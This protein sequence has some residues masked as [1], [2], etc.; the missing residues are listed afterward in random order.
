MDGLNLAWDLEDMKWPALSR[1]K[2]PEIFVDHK[3]SMSQ[4]QGI[5]AAKTSV[6]SNEWS[7]ECKDHII[8][9]RLY[10]ILDVMF[11]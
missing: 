1:V 8:L 2:P 9:G 10:L 11:K 4:P 5:E 6:N 3:L 7:R